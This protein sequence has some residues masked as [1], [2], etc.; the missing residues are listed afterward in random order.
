MTSR[1][2]IRHLPFL[3]PVRADAFFHTVGQSIY[4]PIYLPRANGTCASRTG[5][6]R[7]EGA[8]ELAKQRPGAHP[9][10]VHVGFAHQERPRL[11]QAVSRG[12]VVR[13]GEARQ[14]GGGGRGLDTKG[15][16]VVLRGV[17]DAVQRAN[18]RP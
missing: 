1:S 4:S 14:S 2:V 6:P 16:K 8:A 9:E 11:P 18:E 7:V 5:G 13:R 3:F 17:R 12:G 10:L 15:A